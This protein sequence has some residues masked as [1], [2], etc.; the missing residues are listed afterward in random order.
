MAIALGLAAAPA[1]A[2][3]G[4]EWLARMG[5]ALSNAS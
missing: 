2:E 4:Q 1:F 3:S 5:A